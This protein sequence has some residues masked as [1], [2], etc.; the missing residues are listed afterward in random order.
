MKFI[1][2]FVEMIYWIQIF[3]CP[4]ILIG[5]VGLASYGYMKNTTGML[6]FFVFIVLGI[7]TGI[8]FAE[9]VRRRI[10]CSTFMSRVMGRSTA[11]EPKN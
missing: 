9:R 11:D 5:L 3:L 2:F 7:G 1:S 4:T 6:L 8:Y 10:G